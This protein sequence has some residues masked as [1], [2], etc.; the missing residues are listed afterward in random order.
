MIWYESKN[1]IYVIPV[2]FIAK[3]KNESYPRIFH[4]D[5]YFIF[6]KRKLNIPIAIIEIE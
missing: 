4:G 5:R 1:P 6:S 2:L 3:V